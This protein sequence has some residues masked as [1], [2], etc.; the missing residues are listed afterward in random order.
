[1]ATVT[2]LPSALDAQINRTLHRINKERTR[3]RWLA[4]LMMVTGAICLV[5]IL[6]AAA[7]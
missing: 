4:A 7:H 5:A 1:M 2:Y 3:K 6:W